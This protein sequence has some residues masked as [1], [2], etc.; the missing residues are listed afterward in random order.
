MIDALSVISI[1]LIIGAFALFQNSLKLL[2]P[3]QLET[4]R[5]EKLFSGWYLTILC[6][7]FVGMVLVDDIRIALFLGIVAIVC[8]VYEHWKNYRSVER[9]DA[10]ADFKRRM[11]VIAW[12]ADAVVIVVTV[13]SVAL[14][15]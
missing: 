11:S 4:F 10:P 15:P 2:S 12:L 13:D 3:T 1:A 8:A 9:L 6:V 7:I 5:R 14:F